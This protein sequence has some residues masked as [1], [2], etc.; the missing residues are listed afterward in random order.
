MVIE[1]LNNTTHITHGNYLTY[2]DLPYLSLKKVIQEIKKLFPKGAVTI[3][4][5]QEIS[6]DAHDE[7]MEFYEAENILTQTD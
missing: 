3:L 7:L 2:D 5:F 1:Q 6:K 4:N